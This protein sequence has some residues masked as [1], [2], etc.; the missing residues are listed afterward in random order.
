[1]LFV[2]KLGR[3]ANLGMRTKADVHGI[4]SVTF[5]KFSNH[6]YI[7]FILDLEREFKQLVWLIAD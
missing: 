1:M 2:V 6:Y 5:W 3:Y 7:V 4:K